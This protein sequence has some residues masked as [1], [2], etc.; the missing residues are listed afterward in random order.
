MYTKLKDKCWTACFSR[1][2]YELY[3]IIKNLKVLPNQVICNQI[4]DSL[5]IDKNLKYILSDNKIDITYVSKSPTIDEYYLFLQP[6]QNH[7]V[8]LHGWMRIIPPEICEKFEIY[9]GHP[10][11]ITTYPELKGKDPQKKAFEL[12]HKKIGTVIHR[13]TAGVDEGEVL[14]SSSIN[15]TFLDE[16]SIFIAL[17]DVSIGLW[18]NFLTNKLKK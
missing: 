12:E 13:V 17:R 2:G 11:L 9:N 5:K 7:I 6:D 10:G 4:P 15:N 1:T 3:V 18:A 8:S 14:A 16:E